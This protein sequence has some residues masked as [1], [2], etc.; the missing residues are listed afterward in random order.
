[1]LPSGAI[2]ATRRSAGAPATVAW[3]VSPR[4]QLDVGV[5]KS[6]AT[7][8]IISSAALTRPPGEKGAPNG[9]RS[10]VS[11]NARASPTGMKFLTLRRLRA[12]RILRCVIVRVFLAG[13]EMFK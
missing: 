8:L 3:A 6:A 7:V 1:M 13:W 11:K 10:V 5:V 2:Q 9:A 4:F 12:G